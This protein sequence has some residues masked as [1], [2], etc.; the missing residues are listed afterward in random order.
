[1]KNHT[2]VLGFVA[3]LIAGVAWASPESA[4]KAAG[5]SFLDRLDA[6]K[7]GFISKEEAAPMEGLTQLFDKIDIS[8]DGK[9]DKDELGAIHGGAH[10]NTHPGEKGG[11]HGA[12]IHGT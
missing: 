7:D 4:D 10:G 11:A 8:K 6:N 1:M 9:L 5:G 12:D 2:L 3:V